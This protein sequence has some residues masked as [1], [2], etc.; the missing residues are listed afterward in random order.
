MKK[1]LDGL[2]SAASVTIG[3]GFGLWVTVQLFSNLRPHGD[4]ARVEP[5]PQVYEEAPS[6]GEPPPL[7]DWRARRQ[8]SREASL[9]RSEERLN[10]EA[11]AWLARQRLNA[12]TREFERETGRYGLR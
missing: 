6:Y 1:L 11:A 2:L 7:P 9:M 5:V 8:A 3:I 12:E 4:S 10:N